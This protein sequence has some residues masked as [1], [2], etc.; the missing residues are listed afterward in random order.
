MTLTALRVCAECLALV[1]V[2]V[3]VEL[4]AVVELARDVDVLAEHFES[5]VGQDLELVG[6]L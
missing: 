6:L 5:G 2:A 4:E 1:Q 3:Y